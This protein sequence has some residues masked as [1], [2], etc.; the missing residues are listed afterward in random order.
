MSQLPLILGTVSFVV[1][2]QLLLKT[3]M[4][5]V[6]V[7]DGERLRSPLRLVVDVVRT[8]AVVL[9][10]G[11]YGASALAWIVVLSRTELSFAYPFLSLAYVIVTV[12]AMV[13]LGER[14]SARQWAGLVAVVA[15]VL[16]VA[17]SAG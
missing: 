14:F 12:A 9:G 11:I 1:C 13:L 3:G 17:L 5:R 10:L 6:G 15:G 16:L 8:P 7:I 2:G 4:R